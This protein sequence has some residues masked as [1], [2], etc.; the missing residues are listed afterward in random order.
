MLGGIEEGGDPDLAEIIGAGD[1]VGA[2]REFIDRGEEETGETGDD[3]GGGKKLDE[4]EGA[5][6]LLHCAAAF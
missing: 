3:G 2:V 5:G 6:R 1:G 4:G